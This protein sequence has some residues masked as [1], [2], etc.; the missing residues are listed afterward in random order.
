M[1][2][3]ISIIIPCHNASAYVDRCLQSLVNQTIGFENLQVILVDD[4][5]EDDTLSKLQ[6]YEQIYP[7][8]IAVITY[9]QNMGP[10]GA[11]NIGLEYAEADYIG[12]CDIDDWV[13]PDMYRL[14]Y[15]RI[16]IEDNGCDPDK[17]RY[18]DIVYCK[19]T[20]D[21]AV[22]SSAENRRDVYYHFTQNSGFYWGKDEITDKGN[23]GLFLRSCCT[24]IFRKSLLT[25][26]GIY[27]LEGLIHEDIFWMELVSLYAAS[28]YIVDLILYHYEINP[29]SITTGN[30][31]SRILDRLEVE[32]R[33]VDEYAKRG[34]LEY[35][36]PAIIADFMNRFYINTLYMLFTRFDVCPN[37]YADM[38]RII[39]NLFPD[40]DKYLHIESQSRSIQLL[41]RLLTIRE[42][43]TDTELEEVKKKFMEMNSSS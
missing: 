16:R 41:L 34:A 2:P 32:T 39:Y 8:Q 21:P 38:H 12:Y 11:R 23:N 20:R 3:L 42:D 33:L 31:D 43:M 17:Q 24:G 18:Y 10:G 40:W 4:A 30:N 19:Y 7:E 27:F 1:K 5:S 36:K 22:H 37:V 28:A 9:P 26:N 35:Y 25:D 29:N 6:S 13:E 15:E 14:L